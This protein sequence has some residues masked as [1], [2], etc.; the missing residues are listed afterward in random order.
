MTDTGRAARSGS[1]LRIL[2]T[3]NT[4][5]ARAGSELFVRDLAISLMKRGHFPVVY[6]RLLGD[7]ANELSLATIPVINDL[8][9]LG[10]PPDIIHGQHHLET[11]TAALRFPLTP[12][13]FVCH[14]WRPWEEDPPILPSILHYVAVDDLCRERLVATKGINPADISVITNFVDLAQFPQRSEWSD[15]PRSALVFSNY[16]QPGDLRTNTI[17]AACRRVGIAQLDI[18]GIGAGNAHPDPG[19]I[20]SNYDVVFAKARSALEAMA[21]GAAVIVT[22]YAGLAGLVTPDNVGRLRQWN[23]GARTMQSFPVTEENLVREL[24]FYDT[25]SIRRVSDLIRLEASLEQATDHWLSLYDRVLSKHAKHGG[26]EADLLL[27][28]TSAA[29]NYVRSLSELVKGRHTAETNAQLAEIAKAETSAAHAALLDEI[30]KARGDID[31]HASPGNMKSQPDV[32]PPSALVSKIA[33]LETELQAHR[34]T[35]AAIKGSRAW[36]LV[37]RYGRIKKKFLSELT[38]R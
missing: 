38:R 6:S 17:R 11:V 36:R 18:I 27:K 22:D 13:I 24:Q 4:L 26:G 34:Q 5:G 3:N 37:T 33:A 21:T 19:Q 32:D 2:L 35:L 9:Q 29:S 12:A 28:Q 1:G 10:A 23:F 14:G 7:V 16:A 15:R 25:P 30:A 20:L 31:E 8:D